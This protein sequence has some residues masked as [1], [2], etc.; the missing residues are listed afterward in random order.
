MAELDVVSEITGVTIASPPVV[1]FTLKTAGGSGIEGLVPLWEASS[2]NRYVR[3]TITK[4]V[5]GQNGDPDSWVAYTRDA[6]SG[7]P[8]YDTGSSLVDNGGG[9]YT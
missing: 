9:S 5:V 1:T 3:F 6:T 4:L 7:D 8:D 2:G